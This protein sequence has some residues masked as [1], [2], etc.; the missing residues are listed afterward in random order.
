MKTLFQS[1]RMRRAL[2]LSAVLTTTQFGV[3]SAQT[4]DD[5]QLGVVVDSICATGALSVALDLGA[6]SP[7]SA[8]PSLQTNDTTRE[9]V[10]CMETTPETMF[11]VGTVVSWDSDAS[12]GF[13][14]KDAVKDIAEFYYGRMLTLY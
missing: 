11:A 10:V 12:G 14:I 2:M 6:S 13:R 1:T 4:G 3:V 8:D 5:S 9:R 7:S